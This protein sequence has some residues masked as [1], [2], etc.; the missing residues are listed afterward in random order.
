MKK[1][2]IITTLSII[3]LTIWNEI[4]EKNLK[5]ME[6]PLFITHEGF[7]IYHGDEYWAFQNESKTDAAKC[8]ADKMWLYND[9]AER[10]KFK[11]TAQH[12]IEVFKWLNET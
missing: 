7:P 2:G 12:A 11:E 1:I 10:F 3:V 8:I 5:K 4:I 9:G 6:E